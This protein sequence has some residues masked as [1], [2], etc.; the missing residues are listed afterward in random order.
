M[1]AMEQDRFTGRPSSQPCQNAHYVNHVIYIYKTC[2]LYLQQ[3]NV[4]T[5]QQTGW[6]QKDFSEKEKV[7][8]F[9]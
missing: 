3:H 7:L 2:H 5:V 6:D 1:N 8:L 4:I 9:I